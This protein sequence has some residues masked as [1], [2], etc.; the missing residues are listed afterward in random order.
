MCNNKIFFIIF[1][2]YIFQW[3]ILIGVIIS[4]ILIGILSFILYHNYN[5]FMMKQKVCT[6]SKCKWTETILQHN[7]LYI[8]HE[9]K[10]KR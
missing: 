9:S 10:V 3:F 7:I 8:K 5:F 1:S 2:N 4:C 6:I